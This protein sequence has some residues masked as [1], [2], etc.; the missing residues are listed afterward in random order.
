MGNEDG[1]PTIIASTV[2]WA[3]NQSG[4][5][6]RGVLKGPAQ[7]VPLMT[8]AES[9][10]LQAEAQLKGLFGA[11]DVAAAATA[12]RSGVEASFNYIFMDE[13]EVERL[14]GKR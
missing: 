14:A 12:Y 2:T 11:A 9:Y 4:Y 6:G 13:N 10:F 3:S 8:A 1:A 7:G 5:T